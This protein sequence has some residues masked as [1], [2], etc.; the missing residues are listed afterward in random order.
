MSFGLF[1]TKWCFSHFFRRFG[2]YVEIMS[3]MVPFYM[4]HER[5]GT[6]FYGHEQY[7]T[8]FMEHERDG[9][10]FYGHE[11]NGAFLYGP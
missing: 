11:Q 6:F 9:T 7:G 10:F 5:D 1:L 3:E 4:G 8:F 2:A